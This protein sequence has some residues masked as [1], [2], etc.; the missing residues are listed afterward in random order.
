MFFFFPG[1]FDVEN[2]HGI[3][4]VGFAPINELNHRDIGWVLY[5]FMILRQTSSVFSMGMRLEFGGKKCLFCIEAVVGVT[6]SIANDL[7]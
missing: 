3:A 5:N 6:I 7:R 2:G 1:I 4:T